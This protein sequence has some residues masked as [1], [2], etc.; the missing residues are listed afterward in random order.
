MQGLRLKRNRIIPVA[1][2]GRFVTLAPEAIVDANIGKI[3]ENVQLGM[4]KSQGDERTTGE[5]IRWPLKMPATLL[6]HA[7]RLRQFFV[8]LKR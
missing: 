1:I 2:V 8:C 3:I 6:T 5:H 4:S 7:I